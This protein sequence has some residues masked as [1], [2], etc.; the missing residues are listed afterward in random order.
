MLAAVLGLGR[1]RMYRSSLAGHFTKSVADAT[2]QSLP[3][4]SAEANVL[5]NYLNL[6]IHNN[7][8]LP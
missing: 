2:I 5:R 4:H 1:M 8:E 3:F 7:R 6:K